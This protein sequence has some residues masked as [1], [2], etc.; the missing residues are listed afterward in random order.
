MAE[1][2]ADREV[3]FRLRAETDPRSDDA[4][5]RMGK[6]SAEV[7]AQMDRGVSRGSAARLATVERGLRAEVA[8]ERRA[9]AERQQI[10][11]GAGRQ[12][13]SEPT[14][15]PA[16]RRFESTETS[17]PARQPTRSPD[18][19]TPYAE[20][21]QFARRY[22]QK[23][24]ELRQASDR[25]AVAGTRRQLA[26]REKALATESHLEKQRVAES[27]TARAQQADASEKAAKSEVGRVDKV[28][29][30]AAQSLQKTQEKRVKEHAAALERVESAEARLNDATIQSMEGLVKMGEGIATLGILGEKSTERLV[31]G[32]LKVKATADIL[33]G[34]IEIWRG[35]CAAAKAF[36][37][38]NTAAQAAEIT[39]RRANIKLIGTEVAALK[40]KAAANVVAS[41]TTGVSGGGGIVRNIAGRAMGAA[42]GIAKAGLVAAKLGAVALVAAE[43]LQA[44]RRGL[45]DTSKNSESIVGA[46]LSWRRAA[47]DAKQ[48]TEELSKAE[49]KRHNA[50][51]LGE[52]KAKTVRADYEYSDKMRVVRTNQ[53]TRQMERDADRR[54]LR[55]DQRDA[56]VA[57]G[58]QQHETAGVW[59]SQKQ[60]D[61]AR[62]SLS[63]ARQNNDMVG[64]MEAQAQVEQARQAA[65]AASDR[66]TSATRDRLD[67]E[68]RI[69]QARLD[70]ADKAIQKAKQELDAR[71]EAIKTEQQR[72]MSAKERFGQM[73][74]GEQRELIRIKQRA[75][76]GARLSVQDAQKLQGLGTRDTEK[77]ASS[78]FRQR[79]KEGGFSDFFGAGER[80]EV[81]RLKKE[82]EKL[83]V[84][85]KDQRELK[86]T[87]VRD[88]NALVARLRK[89]IEHEMAIRDDRLVELIE[90]GNTRTKSE[91]NRQFE[92]RRSAENAAE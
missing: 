91:I 8:A 53:A 63:T 49:N 25:A 5:A 45:G 15:S 18:V 73:S 84:E 60:L 59:D 80:Q 4:F 37:A 7:Q 48:S 12:R 81:N 6:Q 41:S 24:D 70:A 58:R 1:G 64:S 9:A 50:R 83:S 26:A 82:A 19:E 79:A 89:T 66:L 86:V 38:I 43:G 16:G 71:K 22:H 61:Q 88:D 57:R 78:E 92:F 29:K 77:I 46:L 33:R 42:G 2:Q 51:A 62:Q 52:A 31:R 44:V 21:E 36:A 35:M 40:G 47:A 56:F 54:G 75:D 28:R 17:E 34:G 10:R 74:R 87:I 32:F 23:A 11:Q 55:G 67:V 14:A 30:Q 90:Q 72:F 69:G 13:V 85:I 20:A 76:S 39:A 65:I 3:L 68:K 27:A